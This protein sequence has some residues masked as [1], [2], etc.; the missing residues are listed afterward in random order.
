[1]AKSGSSEKKRSGRRDCS[2]VHAEAVLRVFPG[3]AIPI[4]DQVHRPSTIGD[5]KCL[6]FVSLNE[7]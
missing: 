5:M 6:Y 4:D 2:N 1:M 3:C 7:S